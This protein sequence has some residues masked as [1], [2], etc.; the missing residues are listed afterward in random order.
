VIDLAYAMGLPPSGGS[1]PTSML[2]QLVPMIL[3]FAIF[4][5]LL[6][7]P[8]QRERK[9]RDE[10]LSSL[11]KGDRIV[12]SGGLIGTIVGLNE[13]TVTL[14][15]ADSVRVECLRSAITGLY[16]PADAEKESA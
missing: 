2:I 14:R 13:R 6:I 11:K 8:Q 7:R 1:G 9:R 4:F 3:V 16:S 15:V 10:M 5:F 12:T